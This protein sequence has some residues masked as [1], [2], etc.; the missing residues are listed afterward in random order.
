MV[1]SKGTEYKIV[2]IGSTG[3]GKSSLCTQFTRNKFQERYEPT[4]EDYYRREAILDGDEVVFDIIDTAGQEGNLTNLDMLMSQGSGFLLVYDITRKDSY[5]EVQVFYDRILNIKNVSNPPI[6]LV[7]NKLDMAV[8][9]TISFDEGMSLGRKWNCK[10]YEVSAKTKTNLETSFY[11]CA[12]LIKQQETGKHG[13]K[14][15]CFIL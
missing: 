11:E 14:K 15:C 6:I 12:R 13:P 9:R 10:F 4:I 8:K 7:G 5:A 2:L 3:V 1:E